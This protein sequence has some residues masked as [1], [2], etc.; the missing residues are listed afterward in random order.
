M[1]ACV[2]ALDALDAI[3]APR[4]KRDVRSLG[5]QFPDKRQSQAGCAAGNSRSQASK[6]VLKVGG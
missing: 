3:A 5:K 6:S 2:A 1:C 4:D